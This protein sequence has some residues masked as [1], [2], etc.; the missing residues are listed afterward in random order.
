MLLQDPNM[1]PTDRYLKSLYQ[2]QYDANMKNT[3]ALQLPCG[4]ANI[5]L[6]KPGDAYLQCPKCFRK[7]QL[8][9]SGINNKV[10]EL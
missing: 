7:F 9:W 1:K 4:H 6:D 5:Q 3:Y 2:E 10:K 8:V